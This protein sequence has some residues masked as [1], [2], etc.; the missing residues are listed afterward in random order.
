MNIKGPDFICIG[1]QKAGT[2]WLYKMLSMHHEIL[3]LKRKNGKVIKEVHF[4]DIFYKNGIEWYIKLFNQNNSIKYGDITPAYSILPK[5][6][7]REMHEFNNN[8]PIIFIV[9]NPID[10]AYSLA[11]M[12]VNHYNLN[13]NELDDQWFYDQFKL[14]ASIQRGNYA[15]ILENYYTFFTKEQILLINYNDI[16]Q[17][18]LEVL[19]K[20]SNHINIDY[21]FFKKLDNDIITEKVFSNYS[22][23]KMPKKYFDFLHKIYKLKIDKAKEYIPWDI[24]E[25]HKY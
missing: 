25:W 7:I 11:K 19:K 5:K 21:N 13:F 1:A 4:W 3:F 16:S 18:P 22:D 20:I 17:K 2:T 24:D 23:N 15:R 9:R 12:N 8:I 6:I 14:K 10:R